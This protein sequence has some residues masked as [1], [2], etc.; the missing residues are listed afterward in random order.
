M[1]ELDFHGAALFIKEK[2]N[3]VRAYQSESINFKDINV[4]M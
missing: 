1:K 2:I 3:D 4:A